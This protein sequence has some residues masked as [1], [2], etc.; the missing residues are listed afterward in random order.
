MNST[1]RIRAD[2]ILSIT[3]PPIQ[4]GVVEI[5]DGVIRSVEPYRS[6]QSVIDAGSVCLMPGL[7][8]A[9]TH[10]EFSDL[11]MPLGY[12]GIEFTEWVRKVIRYRQDSSADS[13]DAIQNGLAESARMGTVAIGE[14]AT[15]SWNDPNLQR[16]PLALTMFLERLGNDPDKHSGIVDGANTFLSSPLDGIVRGLSPHAPYSVPLELLKG[17][18]SAAERSNA[19]VAMHLAET[20]QELQYLQDGTGSFR[21]L[22]GDLGALHTHTIPRERSIL[23]YLHCLKSV[24]RC[25]I[26]H[27]NYLTEDELDFIASSRN[28]SVVYCPRTHHFFQH[29]RFPL[30]SILERGINL[31]VGTDSRASNPDLSVWRELRLVADLFPQLERN[32]I[33]EMGTLNGAKALGCERQF[34]SIEPGKSASLLSVE[35]ESKTTSPID[36]IF[37]QDNVEPA[38]IALA[39][40][41]GD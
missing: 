20:K 11:A 3:Q 39:E 19:P 34:G 21:D 4:N 14:I 29:D 30:N 35:L 1:L 31:A 22:L 7:V 25:L 15:Q 26:V 37:N 6:G 9:H 32:H 5:E 40:F 13:L 27:G 17:L 28:F 18:T 10:L 2:W 23:D 12:Q 16:L 8:N 33:L 41:S 38:P 36:T 24:S